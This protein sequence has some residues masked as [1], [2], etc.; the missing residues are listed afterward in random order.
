MLSDAVRSR[1]AS[2]GGLDGWAVKVLQA[3][4]RWFNGLAAILGKVGH[5]HGPQS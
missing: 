4:P 1:S 2:G 3:L 5:C